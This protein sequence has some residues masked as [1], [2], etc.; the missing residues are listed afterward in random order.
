M[1][2]NKSLALFGLVIGL[3]WCNGATKSFIHKTEEEQNIVLNN[4]IKNATSTQTVTLR[5]MADY[6]QGK[7][8]HYPL[9]DEFI[10]RYQ[11]TGDGYISYAKTLGMTVSKEL[12]LPDQKWHFFDSWLY[13]TV[14]G[15]TSITYESNAMSCVYNSLKCPELLLWIFE[16]CEV[17]PSKVKAAK[18]AAEAGKVAGEN[19]GRIAKNMRT[20][21]PWDDIVN[22]ILNNK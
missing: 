21:V 4:K 20:C 6:L 3:S 14:D 15:S 13:R 7:K 17:E 16:A 5:I 8:A 9:S 19:V 22:N 1:K 11:Q 18:D 10:E 12:H 2:K